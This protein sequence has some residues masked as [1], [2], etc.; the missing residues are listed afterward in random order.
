MA[1]AGLLVGGSHLHL[2]HRCVRSGAV[3]LIWI[4]IGNNVSVLGAFAMPESNLFG[5]RGICPAGSF[6]PSILGL[7]TAGALTAPGGGISR[8]PVALA[9]APAALVGAV[10]GFALGGSVYRLSLID[11]RRSDR[12]PNAPAPRS[13][14]RSLAERGFDRRFEQLRFGQKGVV[15]FGGMHPMPLDRNAGLGEL[16]H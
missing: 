11:G 14:R 2:S 3:A 10:V 1:V 15:T 6:C 4:S 5:N 8:P 13:S 9:R 16:E 12:K 7:M